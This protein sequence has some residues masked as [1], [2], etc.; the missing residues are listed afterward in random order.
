MEH[1]EIV[2]LKDYARMLRLDTAPFN[3]CLDTG[4]EA[5]AVQE[6]T[7]AG[8]RIGINGTPAFFINGH[9]LSGVVS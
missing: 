6:D 9:F 8:T 1:L 7:D 3:P 4:T 5:P 2:K